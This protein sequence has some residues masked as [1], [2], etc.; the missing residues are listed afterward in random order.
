MS[1]FGILEI[2]DLCNIELAASGMANR[3]GMTNLPDKSFVWTNLA[4][5]RQLN[6]AI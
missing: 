6:N 3:N 4:S 2:E 1:R 5:G